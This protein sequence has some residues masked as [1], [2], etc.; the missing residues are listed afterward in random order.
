[1]RYDLAARRVVPVRLDRGV[2][3]FD[4]GLFGEHGVAADGVD[5]EAVAAHC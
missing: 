3:A 4:E 1:M 2:A 5:V